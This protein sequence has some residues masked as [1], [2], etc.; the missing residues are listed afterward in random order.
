MLSQV[1]TQMTRSPLRLAGRCFLFVAWVLAMG[2]PIAR[3]Q[4]TAFTYQ[5]E[6]SQSGSPVNGIYDLHFQVFDA[7]SG[8]TQT[9]STVCVDNVQ[10]ANGKFTAVVDVGPEFA[11]SAARYLEIGVRQDTGLDCASAGGFDILAPRQ[12]ISAAPFATHANSAFALDAPDGSPLNA[13][14]VADNGNVGIGTESPV[15]TLHIKTDQSGQG[16]RIQGTTAGP[17]NLA[18]L[19]FANDVGGG[20]GARVGYV[21]EG[22]GGSSN[23]YLAADSGSVALH[24]TG[25]DVLTATQGANVGIGTAAPAAKLDVRG[26]IRMGASGEFYAVKS[27]TSDRILRGQINANGTIDAS[28]SS[29]GFTVTHSATGTYVINFTTAFT[30]PPVVTTSSMSQ[31]CYCYL[32]QTQTTFATIFK[33]NYTTGASTDSP[34]QFVAIGR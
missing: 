13:V 33:Q 9:G 20:A 23:I 6:L 24:T 4:S 26:D 10:V 3:A 32:S 27:P 5:G 29:G 21:G 1:R 8:G 28:R 19:A 30:S 11:T 2:A 34:F 15:A 16:L 14:K 31:C 18:Y 12:L 25:G 17:G 7:L 22:S